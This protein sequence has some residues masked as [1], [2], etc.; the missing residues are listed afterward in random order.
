MLQLGCLYMYPQ[1][2]VAMQE[3]FN[4]GRVD[5][6][7]DHQP[8]DCVLGVLDHVGG[9]GLL[10]WHEGLSRSIASYENFCLIVTGNHGR[11]V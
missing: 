7:E 1:P 5:V 11:P 6:D 2:H 9:L 4:R 3:D 8:I 10:L